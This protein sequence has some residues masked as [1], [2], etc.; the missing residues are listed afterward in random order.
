M[1][2][3]GALISFFKNP[4]AFAVPSN[5]RLPLEFIL[6]LCAVRL[7]VLAHL[8]PERVPVGREGVHWVPWRGQKCLEGLHCID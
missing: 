6:A 1:G 3:H 5:F 8:Q 4:G 2:G 7:G